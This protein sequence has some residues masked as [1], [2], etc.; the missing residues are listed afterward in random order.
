MRSVFVP[1]V[2][3]WLKIRPNGR[4]HLHMPIQ[5]SQ[6]ILSSLSLSIKLS[7]R[8]CHLSFP[9]SHCVDLNRPRSRIKYEQTWTKISVLRFHSSVPTS[10]LYQLQSSPTKVVVLL[11]SSSS[12][13]SSTE[14]PFHLFL[15]E[16]SKNEVFGPTVQFTKIRTAQRLC[17]H[18]ASRFRQKKTNK[19]HLA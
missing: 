15:V 14:I 9:F 5:M 12:S 19:P 18:T 17:C 1:D 16:I 10:S 3:D 13:S 2:R 6:N 4:F 8:Y 11:S 7:V